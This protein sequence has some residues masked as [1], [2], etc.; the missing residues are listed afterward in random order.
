MGPHERRS[1]VRQRMQY[2]LL[3]KRI[4]S[5][6]MKLLTR[7]TAPSSGFCGNS[8]HMHISPGIYTHEQIIKN[9]GSL[10]KSAFFLFPL[11]ILKLCCL[12]SFSVSIPSISNAVQFVHVTFHLESPQHPLALRT[13]P[14][15]PSYTSGIQSILPPL[16][17]LLYLTS[18]FAFRVLTMFCS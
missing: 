12:E 11:K 8:M 3:L 10:L 4:F 14:E 2:L 17:L 6:H 1:S 16:C 18:Q 9:K 13:L 5:T 7:D 15:K